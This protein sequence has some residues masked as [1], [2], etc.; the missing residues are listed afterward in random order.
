[1]MIGAF[2]VMGGLVLLGVIMFILSVTT[3]RNKQL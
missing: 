2:L 1:M 3:L